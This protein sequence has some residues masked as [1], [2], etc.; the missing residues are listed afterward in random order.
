MDWKYAELIKSFVA[1][2]LKVKYKSTALGLLWWVLNPL[3]LMAV[4]YLVFSRVFKPG[5]E[6][7]ALFLLLG[8]VL[9]RFF[10]NGTI[11]A[12]RSIYDNSSIVKKV[13][14]PLEILV[15]SSVISALINVLFELGVFFLIS[16]V[17]TKHLYISS[18]WLIPVLLIEFIVILGA[19]FFLAA[20][21]CFYQD[22]NHVWGLVLQLG[23]FLCPVIYPINSI[24][25]EYLK[26]YLLNPMAHIIQISREAVLSGVSPGTGN[27][28]VLLSGGIIILL[29]GYCIFRRNERKLAR[30]I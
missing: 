5:I 29:A 20:F 24:P 27:M 17:I 16:G 7:Y 30:V 15:I 1:A 13:Y 25:V 26:Y 21:F 22:L 4:L 2:D 12:M 18:L 6:N 9:W 3:L 19:G 8:I 28:L 11:S 10:V 23:F 14:F